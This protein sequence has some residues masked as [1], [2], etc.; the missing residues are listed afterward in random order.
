MS[1][2]EALQRLHKQSVKLEAKA[3]TAHSKTLSTYVNALSHFE[4]V[5]QK[6]QGL[7]SQVG[8]IL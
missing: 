3:L 8:V 2:L 5:K 4:E 6:Y 1:E 7:E